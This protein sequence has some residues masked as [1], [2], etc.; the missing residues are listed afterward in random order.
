MDEIEQIS[1]PRAEDEQMRVT[2]AQQGVTIAEQQAS[3]KELQEWLDIATQ[4]MK[5]LENRLSKDSHKSSK[6]L[7][8]R[9]PHLGRTS[10][11]PRFVLNEEAAKTPS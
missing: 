5:Q 11:S 9:H 2:L 4:R 6:P 1:L 3:I 8:R 7:R 10:S